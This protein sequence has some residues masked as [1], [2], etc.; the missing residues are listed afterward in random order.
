[1]GYWLFC[2]RFALVFA[3][4][5]AS[6]SWYPEVQAQSASLLLTWTDTSNNEDGFKIERLVAGLVDA[7][8]TIPVNTNSYID[9]ALVSGTMYCYRVG[10]FNSAGDSDPSNQACAMA[11]GPTVNATANSSVSANPTTI[12]PGGTT[13]ASWSGIV[14]PTT[15]D[16]IGLYAP[17][18]ADTSF[19]NWV[20]VSCST[21]PGSARASGSCSYALPATLSLGNYDLRLF[22]NDGFTRLA[23]TNSLTVT[24][25]ALTASPTTV[26]AGA[27]IT[28]SWSGISAPTPKDWIGLYVPG[29]ADTKFISWVYVSCSMTAGTARASGSCFYLLPATLVAGN[30]ELRLF[31]NDDFTRL[32]TSSLAVTTTGIVSQTPT[33]TVNPKTVKPGS[34]VTAS[35]SGITAPTPKDWIGFYASGAADTKFISWVYVSCSM[36]AGTARASGSC[37][38]A[39]PATLASGNYELRLFVNEGFT[40]LATSG[41]LTVSTSTSTSVVLANVTSIGNGTTTDSTPQIPR[42]WTDYDLKVNLR[43]MNNNSIGMMFRY[44]DDRNYYRFVWNQKSKFRRLEK[45]EN[46]RS[47]V[48]ASDTVGYVKG[49][50]YQAQI[51]AQGATFRVFID[52]AQIFSVVDSSFAEGTV[53]LYASNNQAS[54]DNIVV[55][56]LNTGV[57]LLS[58]DFDDGTLNGWTAVDQGKNHG[59]SVWS[60]T[61]GTLLQT[62]NIDETFALYIARS[63][64]DYRFAAKL[65]S[66]DK[67]PIGVM[68]RYQGSND[69]YRFFWDARAGLRRLE[70]VRNG[71]LTVLAKDA[72]PYVTGTTYNLDITAKGTTIGVQI[73]GNLVFSVVDQSLP[74]GTVAL[75]SSYNPGSSFD[76]VAVQDLVTGTSLLSDDFNDGTFTG[77]TIVDEGTDQRPSAWSVK[78]GRL[79][80]S[81]NIGSNTTNNLGTYALY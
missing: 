38:Y 45:I 51:I 23:T 15:T 11:Q 39:L 58:E 40:R 76:G 5:L 4:F 62:S 65:R 43:S 17:G 22:A 66:L 59:P 73:D 2:K 47:T 50:T 54:F 81:S 12:K 67:G 1:M 60:A 24:N 52:G 57:V 33:L 35:W 10:A 70:K 44:Q 34:T 80:Q 42:E 79:L 75:Y 3:L 28:A 32:A 14:A 29:T 26:S 18:A 13:T 20:Y 69:Y 6:D 30:Y 61:S 21:T 64:T 41:A 8:F 74:K 27:T 78:N 77:W 36:T 19:I 46:G 68:F 53:A 71:A 48:L 31:A 56:D 16:W 25:S 7:T 49:R 37:S 63:W 55:Q 9:S 72:I